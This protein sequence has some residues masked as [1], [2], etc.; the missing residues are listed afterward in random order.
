MS[1]PSEIDYAWTPTTTTRWERPLDEAE[2]FY[3]SLAKAHEA[4]GRVF[5]AMTGAVTCSLPIHGTDRAATERRM[6]D[7]LRRAWLQLRYD[8]PTI[9]ARVEY[10]LHQGRCKKVYETFSDA[11]TPADWL[12][13]TFRVVDAGVT[14]QEWCNSDP[15]VPDLPT[16]FLIKEGSGPHESE[17]RVRA[18]V[19]LRARHDIVDGV[20]TLML[21]ENLFRHAARAYETGPSGYTPPTF[22][23]EWVNLSPP[24]RV[25]AGIPARLSS[26]QEAR[27][28]EILEFNAALK[29]E[30]VEIASVPFNRQ[31]SLPGRHQ[32]VTITLSA[33]TTA[34]VLAACKAA[35]LSITHA[36]HAAIA[37]GVR[38]LQERQPA[39][40]VVRYLNYSLINERGHCAA[41]YSTVA[42]PAALYHSVSGRGLAV[43]L[44]VPASSDSV[45]PVSE[46]T[47]SKEFMDTAGTI[48]DFYLDIRDDA[49]H[50]NLVPSYWAMSTIPYPADGKTPPVPPRN[51]TPSVSISSMGI[52]DRVIRP[53]QGI[54]ELDDPW[55]TG[56]ELGTGLGLFLGTWKGKLTLSGAYNDAFH[57]KEEVLGFLRRCN[58]STLQGLGI[59]Q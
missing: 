59:E 8:H 15:P 47:R 1:S 52:L 56:E 26:E 38:D 46:E 6:G 5:F 43:D 19:V 28:R 48:R 35:A 22:G 50:I 25:A 23:G 51:E 31:A 39:T 57:D 18:T 41:P 29:K 32:R 49:E 44:T 33:E 27:M 37:L 45:D 12:D 34:R 58:Q 3:T 9:A 36:Y 2:Q 55:V 10:A 54:F 24:L 20:G 21:F 42:H 4:T 53:N 40:R 11:Y 17:G 7:A 13:E 14:G 16:L 30:A